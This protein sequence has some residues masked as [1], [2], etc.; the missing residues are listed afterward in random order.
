M[1]VKLKIF[2]IILSL[3]ILYLF[4]VKEHF[5]IDHENYECPLPW[6]NYRSYIVGNKCKVNNS[7]ML[8]DAPKVCCKGKKDM[9]IIEDCLRS[10]QKGDSN[11]GTCYIYNKSYRLKGIEDYPFQNFNTYCYPFSKYRWDVKRKLSNYNL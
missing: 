3:I 1:I 6:R 7:N 2:L 4:Q 9:K 8:L 11:C 5:L 10:N